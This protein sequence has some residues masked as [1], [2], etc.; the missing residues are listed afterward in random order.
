MGW[1]PMASHAGDPRQRRWRLA[2]NVPDLREWAVRVPFGRD[3]SVLNLN[4]LREVAERAGRIKGQGA[5]RKQGYGRY[6]ALIK[7]S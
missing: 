2:N 4:D 6:D 1:W 5:S 7:T 3:E